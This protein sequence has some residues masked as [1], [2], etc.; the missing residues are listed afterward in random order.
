MLAETEAIPVH[1]LEAV[2]CGTFLTLAYYGMLFVLRSEKQL[3]PIH[4]LKVFFLLYSFS[5]FIL[6]YNASVAFSEYY[7]LVFFLPAPL[8]FMF[9]REITSRDIFTKN[10]MQ[11]N[12]FCAYGPHNLCQGKRQSTPSL[13][14]TTRTEPPPPS[15]TRPWQD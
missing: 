3:Y 1:R 7:L 12:S 9:L 6:F 14:V 5:G 15:G 13:R 11:M 8:L 4:F 10:K 2:R